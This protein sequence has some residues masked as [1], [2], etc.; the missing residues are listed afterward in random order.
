MDPLDLLEREILGKLSMLAE[1]RASQYDRPN[2]HRSAPGSLEPPGAFAAPLSPA[3]S[4]VEYHDRRFMAC[5]DKGLSARLTAIAEAE[6][7]YQTAKR[8][9]PAYLD[10]SSDQNIEDRDEAILRWTGRR[11]EWV[12]V[13]EGCSFSHVRKLRRLHKM[14]QTT[15]ERIEVEVA[16]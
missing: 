12:A 4:L 14:N 5:H 15:G 2:L 6:L 9:P 8:R 1:G 11:A 13:M 10:P 16:A 7:D 3:R